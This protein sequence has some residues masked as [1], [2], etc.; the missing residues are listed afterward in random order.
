MFDWKFGKHFEKKKSGL[1]LRSLRDLYIQGEYVA[2]DPIWW[3]FSLP[4]INGIMI[5]DLRSRHGDFVLGN[6]DAIS[7]IPTHML[8]C[9]QDDHFVEDGNAITASTLEHLLIWR[10]DGSSRYVC[11]MLRVLQH[12]RTFTYCIA[13][14][15]EIR[16]V[17]SSGDCGVLHHHSEYAIHR[18]RL[19]VLKPCTPDEQAQSK[20]ICVAPAL[21]SFDAKAV[22][23]ALPANCLEHLILTAGFPTRIQA[24]TLS[25]H[26]IP[27]LKAFPNLT[28]LEI[29]S[30]VLLRA[31]HQATIGDTTRITYKLKSLVDYLPP[32]IRFVRIHLNTCD[33]DIKD[34]FGDLHKRKSE[35]PHLT[36]VISIDPLIDEREDDYIRLRWTWRDTGVRM[37]WNGDD[38]WQAMHITRHDDESRGV[39]LN[40]FEY[41]IRDH[42]RIRTMRGYS[43]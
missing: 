7:A 20:C 35:V 22:V 6:T 32:S 11:R 15:S 27:D 37:S 1:R 18:G 23:D 17:P 13:P 24:L 3:W 25:Q 8:T 26:C 41:N 31:P 42:A 28:H 43:D 33:E 19:D 10:S 39:D 30:S 38:F 29:D 2:T 21:P 36:Q 5:E 9:C 16:A 14:R 34:L 12:L 40:F 4:R